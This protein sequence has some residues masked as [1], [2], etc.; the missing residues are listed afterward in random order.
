M[1]EPSAIDNAIEIYRRPTRVPAV[2][3][4]PLPAGVKDLLIAATD[5]GALYNL[6]DLT[7]LQSTEELREAIAFYI[8]QILLFPEADAYRALGAE[9][10]ASREILRGNMARLLTWLH[11][12]RKTNEDRS[13]YALRVLA[14]WDQL[15]TVQRREQ[16]DL[17]YRSTRLPGSSAARLV[18]HAPSFA[19]A[20]VRRN[21][22]P[23]ARPGSTQRAAV[24]LVQLR[25]RPLFAV[26]GRRLFVLAFAAII[27]LFLFKPNELFFL[28]E[29]YWEM[30]LD[31]GRKWLS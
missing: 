31:E 8:E 3:A 17:L 13:V 15:K 27:G 23:L 29:R 18:D 10:E 2:R 5:D 7:T 24:R 26:W 1:T 14:A 12:D 4:S 28:V 22:V 25:R 9:P 30:F 21:V 19:N 16:Y 6:L 20:K 11:P